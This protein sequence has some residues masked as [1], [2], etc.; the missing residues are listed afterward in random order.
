MQRCNYV[1]MDKPAHGPL[2]SQ[3]HASASAAAA[4][5]AASAPAPAPMVAHARVKVVDKMREW[6]LAR[7]VDCSGVNEPDVAFVE[8][9]ITRIMRETKS[10]GGSSRPHTSVGTDTGISTGT[11]TGTGTGAAAVAANPKNASRLKMEPYLLP[12]YPGGGLVNEFLRIPLRGGKTWIRGSD[13]SMLT[14]RRWVGPGGSAVGSGRSEWAVLLYIFALRRH[15]T[16][17]PSFP[18]LTTSQ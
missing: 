5:A 15:R 7:G 10:G 16:H 3:A 4:S 8:D 13:L 1:E 14:P 11:G 6:L 17:F 2:P 12:V 9:E 18:C